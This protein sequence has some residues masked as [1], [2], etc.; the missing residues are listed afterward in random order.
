MK[1]LKHNV[2]SNKDSMS[3]SRQIAPNFKTINSSTYSYE[4]VL[5][6]S[7]HLMNLFA[8]AFLLELSRWM[9]AYSLV[10]RGTDA[11]SE[12]ANELVLS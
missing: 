5:C 12:E 4:N 7:R 6:V 1:Q 2:M 8:V 3:A 10:L 9:P 11:G